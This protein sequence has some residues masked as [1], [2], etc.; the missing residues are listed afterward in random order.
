[1]GLFGLAAGVLRLLGDTK[2]LLGLEGRW[3]KLGV[4]VDVRVGLYGAG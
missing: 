2:E 3:G 1:M 4:C